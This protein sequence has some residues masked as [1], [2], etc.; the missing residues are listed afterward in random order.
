MML[1]LVVLTILCVL[2]LT[3]KLPR[4]AGVLW[5]LALETSP[6]SWLDNLI[7]DHEMIIGVMKAFGLVLV[8][9]LG[10][11][12]G[13]KRD[14]Y[15][16]GFAFAV[17]FAIGLMHGLYPGLTLL[18]SVR[19]LIGSAG[20]FLFSFARLPPKFIQAV[21]R[22]AILGPL[23]TVGFGGLLTITGLDHMYV[24]EQGALRLGASG[25]PPFLAGFALI[26]VYAG[27]MEYLRTP[28]RVAALMVLINLIIILL[29]GARMPLALALLVTFAL[30][31]IQRRLLLLAAA[32]AVASLG[33]MFLNALTFLR[34]I[35]LAQLGEAADLSNR[36]LVWPYFQAAFLAS[37]FF[38]WGVGAGKVV[39]PVTSRLTSLIGT[40]AAHNEYLRIGAEGG[41]FGLALLIVLI[42]LWVKRG[43]ARLP[44]KQ[45][46]L[47][48]LI[49][50]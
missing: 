2:G 19:S 13:I 12:C 38:G 17:M 39:I 40:N 34:V 49:I 27:L 20:P 43:S 29:T 35:D 1:A 4:I 50:L 18:S 47:M 5:I 21:K 48:R 42:F 24:V 33:L 3:I 31:V 22:A 36:N 32:G 14:R 16:P 28:R 6:D 10:L 9:V 26:G 11:R 15:N 8:A 44:R 41:A 37:P 46:W 23:F 45:L 30:L 7:G 25:E